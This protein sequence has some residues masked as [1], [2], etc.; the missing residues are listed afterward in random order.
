MKHFFFFFFIC[1]Q[2]ITISAQEYA[3]ALDFTFSD[4][5]FDTQNFS[6][7]ESITGIIQLS[8]TKIIATG[9]SRIND[10]LQGF[11][12]KYNTDGTLDVT[13]GDDGIQ[14]IKFEHFLLN[15]S[16]VAITTD[17]K[18]VVIGYISNS[19]IEDGFIARFLSDGRP[20]SSFNDDGWLIVNIG[21]PYE[22][23][24]DVEIQP[25][26]K[27]I[28]VGIADIVANNYTFVVR[29]N[30]DGFLDN[31]FGDEGVYIATIEG[32]FGNSV[33]LLS[34]G[35]IIVG[36]K[37]FSSWDYNA[38]CFRLTED[39]IL[40]LTFSDEGY[41]IIDMEYDDESCEK[42]IGLPSGNIILCTYTAFEGTSRTML[43]GVTSSGLLNNSF[44]SFGSATVDSIKCVDMTVDPDGNYIIAGNLGLFSYDN[45]RI[46][47]IS[48]AGIVDETFGNNGLLSTHFD[49]NSWVNC[50]AI[51]SDGKILLGGYIGEFYHDCAISRHL[52]ED[53][54]GVNS[55]II[56]NNIEVFPNPIVNYCTFTSSIVFD[57]FNLLDITGK[58]IAEIP[59]TVNI[60]EFSSNYHLSIPEALQQGMYVLLA[61]NKNGVVA[62]ELVIK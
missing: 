22:R 33:D 58:I 27:I 29:A 17:D 35:K 60:N 26:G 38:M 53:V 45:F 18:I 25:D 14:I 36:G 55:I 39:G 11:I 15:P 16:D 23:L 24:N 4:D 2:T 56:E 51:Q 20:D 5:G 40:D 10:T 49:D 9:Y 3:G 59:F 57:N 21:E 34:D 19:G 52:A 62:T 50:I 8:D 46:A 43:F 54:V 6:E 37:I 13:F 30:E 44:G 41:F 32:T 31:T 1:C 48:S 12:E 28:T 42:I 7:N 47:K 61:K